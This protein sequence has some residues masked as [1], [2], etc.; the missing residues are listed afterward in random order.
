MIPLLLCLLGL[1]LL[2][3][4]KTVFI[5]HTLQYGAGHSVRTEPGCCSM[6]FGPKSLTIGGR[7]IDIDHLRFVLGKHSRMAKQGI[8]PLLSA[9]E[10]LGISRDQLDILLGIN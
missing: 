7:T 9:H 1:L 5:S 6:Q 3:G 10:E 4:E 8:K 2:V